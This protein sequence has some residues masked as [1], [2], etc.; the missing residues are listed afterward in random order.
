MLDCKSLE[1]IYDKIIET[2]SR[3]SEITKELIKL[4][5][6]KLCYIRDND[7]NK[8]LL[9]TQSEEKFASE[10]ISL[11]KERDF[12]IKTIERVNS[13]KI[14]NISDLISQF[15]GKKAVDLNLVAEKLKMNF[16]NLKQKNDINETLLEV[17]LDQVEVYN[18]MIVGNRA[19][20]TYENAKRSNKYSQDS[21][22]NTRF[23][24]KY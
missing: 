1:E 18:N 22:S 9:I 15:S 4:S 8:I 20:Q 3:Q 5:D 2:L 16:E 19:P 6:E 21:S 11:E 7:T 13:I 23:D 12:L 14:T 24:T 17:I 10:I